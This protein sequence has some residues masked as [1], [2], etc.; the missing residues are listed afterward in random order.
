MT[1]PRRLLWGTACLVLFAAGNFLYSNNGDAATP[2]STIAQPRST[3]KPAAPTRSQATLTTQ[4]G[5]IAI[6]PPD[7]VWNQPIDHLRVHPKSSA[8]LNSIGL[9]TRLHPDWGNEWDG[10][11]IGLPINV[12]RGTQPGVPVRFEYADESDHGLYP[13]PRDVIIEG[14]P[15]STGDRHILLVDF[16]NKR[17]YELFNARNTRSGWTAGSGAIFDL[18]SNRTR[19]RYWTSAD[20]AGLPILPGI[21]RYD[22]VVEKQEIAH[23]LR[24]TVEKSQQGFI[25]PA[26]HFASSA[27]NPNLPPMGLRLRLKKSYDISGFPKS[28]QVILTALKKYGMIL[29]DNGTD[30]FMSGTHH[31]HWNS[32]EMATLKRVQAADLEAIYTGD[33]IR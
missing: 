18:T 27:T 25:Y 4:F 5:E 26:T 10:R 19:P 22:E 30:L 7:N 11:P 3:K 12:V 9:Q 23:A 13:I 2:Q 15:T 24:F 21:V 33:I 6:F 14:G 8:Y 17:L 16:D 20:A 28:V 31:K 32:E 29:A 1:P